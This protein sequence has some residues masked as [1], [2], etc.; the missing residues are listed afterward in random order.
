MYS[1]GQVL[2]KMLQGIQEP[3]PVPESSKDLLLFLVVITA[4]SGISLLWF[5]C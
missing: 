5:Y 1:T 4:K 2:C 3:A